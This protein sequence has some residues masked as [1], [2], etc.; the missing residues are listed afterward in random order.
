[1]TI[2]RQNFKG[3]GQMEEQ[4]TDSKEYVLFR[5]KIEEKGKNQDKRKTQK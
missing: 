1:M 2:E 4:H 3:N 5:E